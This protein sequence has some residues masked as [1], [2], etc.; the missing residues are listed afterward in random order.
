MRPIIAA[1]CAAVATSGWAA[2]EVALPKPFTD[3]DFIT[4]S[5]AEAALGQ[6][7][8]YDPILS[9]N[10]NISCATCHHPRFATGDGLSLGLGE[11]G[12]GLGPER[13]ANPDNPPE[14]RIPRNA[15]PLFNLGLRDIRV[16]FH[17]GRI[18]VDPTRPSGFR[19]PLETDMEQGFVSLLSAQTM[20]P[21]LSP[22]EMAGHYDESDVSQAV[23]RGQLTGE[24]GAWQ[25]LS[26]RVAALPAYADAFAQVYPAIAGGA[27][28]RFTDI[29]NA[30]AAFVAL[31]WRADNSAFDAALRG[32]AP[33]NPQAQR[34]ADLFYGAAGCA[35]CHSGTMLSD[36]GFHAMGQPQ[37][38]PGKAERFENH[39][40]DLGRMRVTGRLSQAYA[41]RTPPLRNVT[42]TGP[43]GHAGAYA[44]LR[45]FLRQHADPAAG[46]ARYQP[47][48]V[49]TKGEVG[50]PDWTILDD[51]AERAEIAAAVTMVPVPLAK[52]DLDALMAFLDS[53]TDAGAITGR[54]GVPDTVPS[55][56]PIDR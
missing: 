5:Q 22:D 9:G 21:V 20:F 37:L 2:Q 13:V 26:Q 56:L 18:E 25:I 44:D 11:G 3:A 19:T 12:I 15:P 41:F 33:L 32:E 1:I 7:L 52:V 50:K 36:Q 4:V 45:A 53:L 38:G 47:Q 51:P 6:L 35:A 17:D 28:I 34:G 46:L 30:I 10:R 14:Q 23:R 8:F 55:G 43:W 16:M 31:E 54:M 24:G 27:P 40:R 42:R 39:Q 49:L 48:A 29:S